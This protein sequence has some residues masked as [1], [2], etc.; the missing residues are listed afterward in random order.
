M[1]GARPS[2]GFSMA[3]TAYHELSQDSCQT[4]P[5]AFRSRDGVARSPKLE[6]L[7]FARP[8]GAVRNEAPAVDGVAAPSL[9]W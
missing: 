1:R 8:H 9:I 6:N 3:V 5:D 4:F 2:P 7:N